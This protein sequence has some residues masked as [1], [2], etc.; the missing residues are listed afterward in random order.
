MGRKRPHLQGQIRKKPPTPVKIAKKQET[1]PPAKRVKDTPL[2][3]TITNAVTTPKPTISDNTRNLLDGCGLN[4][5]ASLSITLTAPKSPNY[6]TSS[7]TDAN[8]LT[9]DNQILPGKVNPTI[10]LNDRS[11]RLQV[12]SENEFEM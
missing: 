10:T 4:I 9:K 12:K 3:C 2:S 6:N 1:A 8:N 7:S 5:P 11:K